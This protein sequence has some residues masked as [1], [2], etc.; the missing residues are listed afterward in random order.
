MSIEELSRIQTRQREQHPINIIEVITLRRIK[1]SF[2]STGF[3]NEKIPKRLIGAE[4]TG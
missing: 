3:S 1:W 4:A 2:K